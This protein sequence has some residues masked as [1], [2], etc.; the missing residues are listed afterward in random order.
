MLLYRNENE[1]D[2]IVCPMFL[3]SDRNSPTDNMYTL[4]WLTIEI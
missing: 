2:S 3:E 1:T 4:A